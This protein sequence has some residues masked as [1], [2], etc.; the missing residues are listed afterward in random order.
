[1]IPGMNPKD[2]AKAMKRMGIKQDEIEAEEVVIKCPD[3]N[4][5]I[6]NPNVVKVN[7]MG[8]E[9]FQ[10]TGDISEE[11]S[12]TKISEEDVKTVSTQ[13][14]VSEQK[15]REALEKYNGDLAEAILSLQE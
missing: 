5:V 11:S 15:A 9:S 10:I 6:S 4:I 8:Q 12:Q 14:N 3:K 1:M 7:A 2:I 13:A